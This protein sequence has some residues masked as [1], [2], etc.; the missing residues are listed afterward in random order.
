MFDSLRVK[1]P[2]TTSKSERRRVADEDAHPHP[3]EE[4]GK[5]CVRNSPMSEIALPQQ[6]T[7][8]KGAPRVAALVCAVLVPSSLARVQSRQFASSPQI[9][10]N[11]TLRALQGDARIEALDADD[12]HFVIKCRMSADGMSS[13]PTEHW[14]GFYI[15]AEV[16]ALGVGKALLVLG[17][18][19]I[20]PAQRLTLM[21]ARRTEG[22]E[23]SAVGKMFLHRIKHNVH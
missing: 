2:L 15:H 12:T 22:A 11:A 16:Q 13:V 21:P 10:F 14:S 5:Q 19:R 18:Q 3:A 7:T 17:V 1:V 6:L 4:V 8:I 20:Y 9:V 23:E